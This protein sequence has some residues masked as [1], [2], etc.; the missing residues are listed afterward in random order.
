MISFIFRTFFTL[1]LVGLIFGLYF[2]NR[3][4]TVPL[5]RGTEVET[6]EV[7][8]RKQTDEGTAE[9][10]GAVVDDVLYGVGKV[11]EKAGEGLQKATE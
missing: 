3:D 5:V 11:A 7:I 8:V 1:V 4:Q 9:K 2:S 6:R 10:M